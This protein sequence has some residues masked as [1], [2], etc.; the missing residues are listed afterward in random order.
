MVPAPIS[1]QSGPHTHQIAEVVGL[2][3]ALAA[4]GAGVEAYVDPDT[5]DDATGTPYK[6][7]AAALASGPKVLWLRCSSTPICHAGLSISN[8]E[9]RA[10]KEPG[11][12]GIRPK[13]WALTNHQSGDFS[14]SSAGAGIYFLSLAVDPNAVWELDANGGLLRFGEAWSAENDPRKPFARASVDLADVRAEAGRWFFGNGPEGQGLYLRPANDVFPALG[15]EL[16]SAN[17]GVE[18]TGLVSLFGLEICGGRDTVLQ[19]SYCLGL[20]QDC[21]IG[22]SGSA[23]ALDLMVQA[24]WHSLRSQFSDAGDDAINTNGNGA[25]YSALHCLYTLNVGDGVAPHGVGNDVRLTSCTMCENGKYGFVSIGTGYFYLQGCTMVRNFVSGMR[26]QLGDHT[27]QTTVEMLNCE[28]NKAK[29]RANDPTTVSVK[30]TNFRGGMEL[31]ANATVFGFWSSGNQRGFRVYGGTVELRDF[32]IT[33]SG[34]AGVEQAGGDLT[35]IGGAVLRGANGFVKS[36]GTTTIHPNSVNI[37]DAGIGAPQGRHLGLDATP[38]AAL[39]SLPQ[40]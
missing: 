30:A 31:Q 26:F 5:G 15:F 3:D 39:V 12:A 22:H 32:K 35:L 10:W 18:A 7:V 14:A 1:E 23:D 34:F 36:G 21:Y 13:L 38:L 4:A 24:R 16:P 20:D 8:I 29:I 9:I 40:I 19:A 6:T 37:P 27:E 11:D 25:A 28:A 33:D 2:S 17:T